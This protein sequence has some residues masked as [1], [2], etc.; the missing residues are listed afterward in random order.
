M[1]VLP[2][3]SSYPDR[4]SQAWHTA[5]AFLSFQEAPFPNCAEI[6]I[7]TQP[8]ASKNVREAIYYFI[9]G[10]EDSNIEENFNLFNWYIGVVRRHFLTWVKPQ[11]AIPPVGHMLLFI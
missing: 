9:G 2:G 11:I 5:T 6:W 7:E 3:S 4:T 1:I 8:N 10:N